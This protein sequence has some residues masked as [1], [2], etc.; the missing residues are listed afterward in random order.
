MA[1]LLA[2]HG[3]EF[4]FMVV[5]VHIMEEL[6]Q[7]RG[8]AAWGKNASWMGERKEKEEEREEGEGEEEERGEKGFF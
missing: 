3:G 4:L 7:E 8:H 1:G 5:V 2:V 6:L